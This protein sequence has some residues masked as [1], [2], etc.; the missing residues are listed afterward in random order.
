MS[1]RFP[2]YSDTPD[3]LD[4]HKFDV[5]VTKNSYLKKAYR[6]PLLI[7]LKNLGLT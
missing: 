2:E 4:I 5:S 1:F 6:C 3:F 7:P